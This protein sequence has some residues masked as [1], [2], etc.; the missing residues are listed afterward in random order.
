MPAV[1]GCGCCVSCNAFNKPVLADFDQ[2]LMPVWVPKAALVEAAVLETLGKGP[3]N[4]LLPG[5]YMGTVQ[6]YVLNFGKDASECTM[7]QHH[8]GPA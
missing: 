2:H 6:W 3:Y 1:G 5:C 8:G 7:C 4:V